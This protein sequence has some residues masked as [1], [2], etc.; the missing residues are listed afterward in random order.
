MFDILQKIKQSHSFLM[1]RKFETQDC[2][3]YPTELSEVNLPSRTMGIVEQG[4]GALDLI[5]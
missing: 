5:S 1:S 3:R 2:Q 4:L